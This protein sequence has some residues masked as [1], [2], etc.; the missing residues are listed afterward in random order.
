ME[1]VYRK[2]IERGLP[3]VVESET[4]TPDGMTEISIC[5]DYLKSLEA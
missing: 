1:A 5:Y 3:I 4:L 2:A